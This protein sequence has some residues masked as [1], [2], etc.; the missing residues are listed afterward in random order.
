MPV[1]FQRRGNGHN[2]FQALRISL[3]S[4]SSKGMQPSGLQEERYIQDKASRTEK[5]KQSVHNIVGR[6]EM[7]NTCKTCINNDDGLC[8]RRGIL[9]EDEDSCKHHCTL[10]RRPKMKKHEKKLDITPQLMI[11]AFNTLIQGCRS[12]PASE[13][14]SC[15]RCIL[16][17][18]CPHI[19]DMIPAD[20][21]EIHYPYLEGNTLHYIKTGEAKQI[22]FA[23][24][25]DAEERLEE[26]KK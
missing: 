7:E 1:L 9:V 14:G 17:Q 13:D 6:I 22:V 8:D 24:R 10:Q 21:E 19:D 15:S 11:S 12:R 2:R 20:W 18:R 4:G 26:M 25:E 5:N 16:Y 23:R 3:N